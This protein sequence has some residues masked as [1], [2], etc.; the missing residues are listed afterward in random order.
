MWR[1]WT[2]Q[3]YPHAL[4]VASAAVC[5][6]LT[7]SS[8]TGQTPDRYAPGAGPQ[9]QTHATDDAPYFHSQAKTRS[10][11]DILEQ[12]R[13]RYL[14][15]HRTL[16]EELELDEVLQTTTNVALADTPERRMVRRQDVVALAPVRDRFGTPDGEYASAGDPLTWQAPDAL[17]Q[18]MYDILEFG[19]VGEV[20]PVTTTQTDAVTDGSTQVLIDVAVLDNTPTTSVALT[21]GFQPPV[22]TPEPV[23]LAQPADTG[24]NVQTAVSLKTE[25]VAQPVSV[26][27]NARTA[28][29][30]TAVAETIP[31]KAQTIT[32]SQVPANQAPALTNKLTTIPAEKTEK[33]A[34]VSARPQP[35]T[36]TL[37]FRTVAKP[38]AE[39]P[40]PD[41]Q[42]VTQSLTAQP[43]VPQ[44]PTAPADT[45]SVKQ[46]PVKK[47][48]PA[49]A[50]TTPKTN[51]PTGKNGN[52]GKTKSQPLV[53]LVDESDAIGPDRLNAIDNALKQVNQAAKRA[54]IDIELTITTDKTV[55]HNILLREND[56]DALNGKLGLAQSASITDDYGNEQ[57]LGQDAS[58]LGGQA[59]AS[60]N[61][62]IDWYAG[63]D[64]NGIGKNQYDYETAV[65]HEIMHLL[66]LDDD[67]GSNE[68]LAM[69]GYLS[70]G[71]TR[72]AIAAA[73]VSELASRYS[74]NNLWQ[75]A[76]KNNSKSTRYNRGSIR[77]HAEAL[78]AA[79]APEPA[80]VMVIGLGLFALA[81]NRTRK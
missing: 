45:K 5:L 81:T 44:Q 63:S 51:V 55:G 62:D 30:T 8:P 47:N 2:R 75:S 10:L 49:A 77:Y 18:R 26:S 33:D 6:M 37:A 69:H 21:E 76:S 53:V 79:P 4:L 29:Q 17:P 40:K 58:H 68:N 46:T 73:E 43:S 64:T 57:R 67:F 65:I 35:D 42:T 3:Y 54:D 48:Q 7:P 32:T 59:I 19:E 20:E 50:Q 71:E 9:V 41:I 22:P 80:S 38:V 56:N 39:D 52:A 34:E 12:A 14:R 27:R 78:T 60:L 70:P 1:T 15:A 24:T 36:P 66:G 28:P 16:P 11:A 72:R 61:S 74:T 31:V 13:I 23:V 25:A